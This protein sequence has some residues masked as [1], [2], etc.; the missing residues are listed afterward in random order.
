MQ[1]ANPLFGPLTRGVA[2]GALAVA[3]GLG[4]MTPAPAHAQDA[5]SRVLVDVADG[6]LNN[7]A[8][9]D[10][11][12]Y[13]QQRGYDRYGRPVYDG[14]GRQGVDYRDHSHRPHGNAYGYYRN[15]GDSRCGEN[16]GRCRNQG[17]HGDDG[18]RDDDQGDDD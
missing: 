12:S 1:S 10:P 11:Y 7:G 13:Q 2:P 8:A 5:L 16:A 15:Q 3:L 9:N 14:Y 17:Q 18:E 4:A 6:L